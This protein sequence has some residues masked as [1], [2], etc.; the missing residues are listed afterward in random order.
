M[1][2]SG[3]FK[4]CSSLEEV[5]FEHLEIKTKYLINMDEMFYGCTNLKRVNFLY[6]NT[7]R[8]K[9]IERM[10]YD[11]TSLNFLNITSF[12][13]PYNDINYKD[14]FKGVP[15][16]HVKVIYIKD[17]LFDEFDTEIERISINNTNN[18]TN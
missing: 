14:V 15:Q 1:D 17:N 4:N 9:S 10:F 3:M 5:K 12:E 8:I 18:N 11:C 16:K 13:I 7:D 6:F 2:I